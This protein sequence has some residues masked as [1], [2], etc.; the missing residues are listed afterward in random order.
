MIEL[1]GTGPRVFISQTSFELFGAYYHRS[2][3]SETIDWCYP[4]LRLSPAPFSRGLIIPT[5]SDTN[6]RFKRIYRR[7]DGLSTISL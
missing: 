6:R 3:T 4:R 1:S 2:Q 7:N 5:F